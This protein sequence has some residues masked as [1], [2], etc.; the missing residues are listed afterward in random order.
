MGDTG[1]IFFANRKAQTKGLKIPRHQNWAFALCKLGL[2][3][4]DWSDLY[5]LLLTLSWPWFLVFASGFFV[6]VNVLFA[7]AYLVQDGGIESARNGSF[8]DAFFFSVETIATVGY[9]AMRPIT[10]FSHIVSTVDN[11]IHWGKR[12]ADII[13]TLPDVQQAIDFTRFHDVAS[14]CP[15]GRFSLCCARHSIALKAVWGWY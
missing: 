11:D 2:A 6:L 8:V 15:V 1:A 9:G 13:L 4:L 7:L 14:R 12:F 10:L 5:H 3:R